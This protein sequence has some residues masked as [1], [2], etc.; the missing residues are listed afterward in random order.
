MVHIATGG[1]PF[2]PK[3][4]AVYVAGRMGMAAFSATPSCPGRGGK[5][6]YPDGHLELPKS[7]NQA[8]VWAK[9][10]YARNYYRDHLRAMRSCVRHIQEMGT[11]DDFTNKT[12]DLYDKWFY[13]DMTCNGISGD[14]QQRSGGAIEGAKGCAVGD[15]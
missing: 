15:P 6:E 2:I 1:I 10:A 13:D 9:K 3:D 11:I 5:Q 8:S 12:S 4:M 14:I 7:A